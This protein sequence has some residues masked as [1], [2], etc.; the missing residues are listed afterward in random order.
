MIQIITGDALIEL[1]KLEPESVQ[2]CVTSPPYWG[3]RDYSVCGCSQKRHASKVA[4]EMC[5]TIVPGAS[6]Q[7]SA[8]DPRC[9]QEPDPGCDMCG[10]TGKIKGTENQLGLEPTPA[11]Y[12]AKLVAVFDEVKR[13]LKDDGVLFLNLGDSY[14]GGGNYRGLNSENT[15]TDKQN[16]NRG[17]RGISQ[18]LGAR[19]KETGCKPK[20][21]IGIPWLVAFALRDSGWY[22]RSDIIWA[23]PNPMPESVTDRPTKS[24]EYLFLL[25]KNQRYYYNAEAIK[26]PAVTEP[27]N[28]GY[29]NGNEYAVG[30]MN[31]NGHS[32]REDPNRVWAGNGLRNKRSVWTV[33]PMPYA[34]AHFATFP[35]DLI[36]PCILAGTKPGDIVLDPF[37]G[38]GTTG[39]VSLEL[40]RQSVLI[41]LNPAY[42]NLAKERCNVT[43]G[44]QL[45]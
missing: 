13:V 23:K 37:S 41:E 24:H 8:T 4:L 45:T 31:R 22:L 40:G 34:E 26:E 1:T 43:P 38:S 30:P 32:Q 39:M 33:N 11:Q 12:V 28:S 18:E 25:S 5:R 20:D 3:L 19:G 35:P 17:A 10:G 42:V 21:L 36:K 14:S 44:L 16:S 27:H 29:A 9:F 2:C 7:S 6:G 15:L